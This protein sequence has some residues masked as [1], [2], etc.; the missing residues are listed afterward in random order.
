MKNYQIEVRF[1]NYQ[2]TEN[3]QRILL[4]LLEENISNSNHQQKKLSNN[5]SD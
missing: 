1:G 3:L 4:L 5:E 2:T